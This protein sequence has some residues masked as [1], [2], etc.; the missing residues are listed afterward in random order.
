MNVSID[1]PAIGKT[2]RPNFSCLQFGTL[3]LWFSYRTVIAFR[4]PET[5]EV[6]SQNLW[7]PTTG[8]H[9]NYISSDHAVRKPREEFERLL[10]MAVEPYIIGELGLAT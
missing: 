2:E 4:T 8:S 6:I 5:G 9:L 7:G 1:H 10:S 3:I